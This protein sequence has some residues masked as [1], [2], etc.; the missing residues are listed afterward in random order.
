ME[1]NIF[2][3]IIDKEMPVDIIFEDEFSMAFHDVNPQA[4]VH[5][6]IIPKQSMAK[7]IDAKESDQALLGHLLLVVTRVAKQLGV[8]DNFRTVI[9]NGT[10]ALQSVFHLHLHLLA[11]RPLHWPPG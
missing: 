6:L 10:G 9:N 7:L 2:Q 11:G 5:V 4:P 3:Q 8:A 1:K